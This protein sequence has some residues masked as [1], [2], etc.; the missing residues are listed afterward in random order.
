M[1]RE[2]DVSTARSNRGL[3]AIPRAQFLERRQNLKRNRQH[4]R[5]S[6][7]EPARKSGEHG[8]EKID[9]TAG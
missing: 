2:F 3:A 6:R 4:W 9:P 1:R 8:L 5:A 7:K